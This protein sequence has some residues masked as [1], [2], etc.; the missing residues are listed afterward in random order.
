MADG[1]T[2]NRCCIHS[3]FGSSW[4]GSV[5]RVCYW[6]LSVCVCVFF[7]KE[8]IST[9]SSR[10]DSRR[11]AHRYRDS[12][13]QK[14]FKA[15]IRQKWSLQMKISLT[16]NTE[17]WKKNKII[18]NDLN[19]VT[20][21]SPGLQ[22]AVEAQ[23]VAM[24]AA[25]K[26][27]QA[28]DQWWQTA[29]LIHLQEEKNKFQNI[30]KSWQR[31]RG[32]AKKPDP[33][34][35]RDVFWGSSEGS[36]SWYPHRSAAGRTCCFRPAPWTWETFPRP[37]PPPPP[38][39][40]HRASSC[41]PS[42]VDGRSSSSA[43]AGGRPISSKKRHNI[44]LHLTLDFWH[45]VN[46]K[47][48]LGTILSPGCP[49]APCC[50]ALAG[51]RWRCA[52]RWHPTRLW[53]KRPDAEFHPLRT[54]RHL[55]H[56]EDQM[57]DGAGSQRVEA[58]EPKEPKEPKVPTSGRQVH[59]P[60][61]RAVDKWGQSPDDKPEEVEN[62]PSEG[63]RTTKHSCYKRVKLN[64]QPLSRSKAASYQIQKPLRAP[65]HSATCSLP[66]CP[67]SAGNT[68]ASPDH[69]VWT[70]CWACSVWPC[71]L[72]KAHTPTVGIQLREQEETWV[73]RVF[74]H[75]L[76]LAG[77]TLWFWTAAPSAARWWPP[78]S[79]RA[80]RHRES[81]SVS[82]H[83]SPPSG[84][85]KLFHLL[86]LHKVLVQLGALSPHQPLVQQ[87]QEEKQGSGSQSRTGCWQGEKK[88][89]NISLR[90]ISGKKHQ[91]EEITIAY[92]FKKIEDE[93]N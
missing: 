43:G 26:V 45:W 89:G 10:L 29:E 39:P 59:Q 34:H 62:Q 31:F 55:L 30:F 88:G 40:F 14:G 83:R 9:L 58:K 64:L 47:A 18:G 15:P 35:L 61:D 48:D 21:G 72:S 27:Q 12:L 17:N 25:V 76:G 11:G 52:G 66:A 41:S 56:P 37:A 85:F 82:P 19:M 8:N 63:D 92:S 91:L 46:C 81:V 50:A 16:V 32:C 93:G 4:A 60:R 75:Y 73:L 44:L 71:P 33:S 1:R 49:S 74:S 23:Q 90:N 80:T 57:Q 28:S 86:H 2:R 3:W 53:P 7:F 42:P 78:R 69:G 5:A 22:V 20:R 79:G 87:L 54:E 84:T 51:G 67:L 77:G 6:L 36:S 13:W 68:P 38:G 70:W 65:G 24:C